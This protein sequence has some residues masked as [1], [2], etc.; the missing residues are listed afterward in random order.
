MK[1]LQESAI[2]FTII[3][4]ILRN[5]YLDTNNP[6]FIINTQEDLCGL[7]LPGYMS[8]AFMANAGKIRLQMNGAVKQLISP[9]MLLFSGYDKINAFEKNTQSI[10]SFSFKPEFVNGNLTPDRLEDG[11]FHDPDDIHDRGLMDMFLTRNDFY[12]G[13]IGLQ[14]QDCLKLSGWLTDMENESLMRNESIADHMHITRN[15]GFGYVRIL[16]RLLQILFLLDDIRGSRYAR[17]QINDDESIVEFITEYIHKNYNSDIS[18]G[19]L[20]HLAHMNR[21][22]LSQKFKKLTGRTPM[23]YLQNY[24]L[25]VACEMLTYSKLSVKKIAEISGYKYDTYFIRQFTEKIG[26]SPTEYRLSEGFETMEGR[27]DSL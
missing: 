17:R 6:Y 20:C 5:I 13:V 11:N 21:T 18:F 8:L 2:L 23:E 1:Y 14:A 27:Y 19:S 9:C 15:D 10:I 25:N 12:S 26:V 22:S 7:P 4:V 16:R 24:R 3:L